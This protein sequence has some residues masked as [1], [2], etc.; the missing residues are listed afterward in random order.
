VFYPKRHDD[1]AKH[2]LGHDIAAT[3]EAEGE[4]A[5]DLLANSPAAARHIAFELARYFVAD[6][7]P[8]ALVDRL[9]ARFSESDGDIRA[10]LQTLFASREFRD[11]TGAKYKSPHRFVL[12]AVRAVGTQVDNPKPLVDALA[13][14]GQPLYGCATPD[15]YRDTA[16]AWLSADAAVLRV[17]FATALAGGHLPLAKEAGT[18][19]SGV[20]AAGLQRLLGPAVAPKTRAVLAAASPAELQAALILGG[21]DFMRR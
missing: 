2:F 10:V 12:S 19:S 11:S 3:G 7:P 20:D 13:R 14:L 1:G 6:Q 18:P 17:N 4:E 21:P 15:G 5:L 9:A 8:S 16:E